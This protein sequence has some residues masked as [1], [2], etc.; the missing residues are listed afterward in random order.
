MGRNSVNP[1]RMPRKNAWKKSMKCCPFAGRES[2]SDCRRGI[3][4]DGGQPEQAKDYVIG[5]A[6]LL[7][8]GISV[9]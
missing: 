3:V 9:A 5:S 1:C 2:L 4:S 8:P 6:S 7:R